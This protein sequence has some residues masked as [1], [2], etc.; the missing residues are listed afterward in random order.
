MDRSVV[1]Q[2]L[3]D[4]CHEVELLGLE[5]PLHQIANFDLCIL[6]HFL[7]VVGLLCFSIDNPHMFFLAALQVAVGRLKLTDP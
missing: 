5:A 7:V 1:L 3:L 4:D 2:F 6:E